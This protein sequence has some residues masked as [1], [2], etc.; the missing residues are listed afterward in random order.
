MPRRWTVILRDQA[1]TARPVR[2]E[3]C[4]GLLNRWWPQPASEHAAAK[5]WAMNGWLRP[6]GDRLHHWTL[7]WLD[8]ENPAPLDPGELVGSA[9]RVGDHVLEPLSATRTFDSSYTEMLT[10][11]RGPAVVR[12]AEVRTQTPVV[13]T[14]RDATGERVPHIWPTPRRL[15]G[16]VH[17]SGGEIV[18]GSGAV[19][20]VA[21]FAP[22]ALA[23]S[24]L[25]EAL[26]GLA[27]VRRSTLPGQEVRLAEHHHA[28]SRTVLG[29]RGGLRLEVAGGGHRG[30][31]TFAALLELLELAGVGKY[32]AQG[33][34][35]VRVDTV[36]QSRLAAQVPAPRS[37]RATR[38]V[39][40]NPPRAADSRAHAVA[41]AEE[42]GGPLFD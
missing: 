40:P 28:E 33:F 24:W 23:A 35:S 37:G 4:H 19:G 12:A 22:P 21:R 9:Q 32:T 31:E 8:D 30:T 18:G 14:T 2:P 1:D 27:Q 17:R 5:R 34:G 16:A 26:T 6:L 13:M 36:T 11:P 38:R 39:R 3:D 15:F 10:A 29:W 7:T 25:E 20:A 41:E 42:F